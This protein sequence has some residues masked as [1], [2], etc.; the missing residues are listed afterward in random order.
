MHRSFSCTVHRPRHGHED[1]APLVAIELLKLVAG[2]PIE[3]DG[4]AGHIHP[5]GKG[6]SGAQHTDQAFLGQICWDWASCST[7][8]PVLEELLRD[9]PQHRQQPSMMQTNTPGTLDTKLWSLGLPCDL[10]EP[11]CNKLTSMQYRKSSN[12]KARKN[13]GLVAVA[14]PKSQNKTAC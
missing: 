12:S 1:L 3:D 10:G 4:S 6:F 7:L 5:H 14:P 2:D 8:P 9:F 11:G 13:H